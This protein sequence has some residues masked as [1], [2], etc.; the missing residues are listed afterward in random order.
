MM[1]A[2]DNYFGL[3]WWNRVFLKSN[4][5]SV[6]SVKGR[7]IF[8]CSLLSV[9]NI[10]LFIN[11]NSSTPS[12]GIS[13]LLLLFVG[14]WLIKTRLNFEPRGRKKR[15]A[16]IKKF[17]VAHFWHQLDSSIWKIESFW[18]PQLMVVLAPFCSNTHSIRL[19]TAE[20]PLTSHSRD[21][22]FSKIFT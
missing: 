13:V 22:S 21:I 1:C 18:L 6:F 15:Q 20:Y 3:I 16:E 17:L 9:C 11:Q 2:M 7:R 14:W 5:L 19:P 8:L 4:S 10:F 12:R